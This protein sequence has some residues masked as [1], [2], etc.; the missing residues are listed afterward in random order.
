VNAIAEPLRPQVVVLA[1][2]LFH[3]EMA[4]SLQRLARTI[5]VS[6][7]AA[8]RMATGEM[9]P[10]PEGAFALNGAT[11]VTQGRTRVAAA[12]A[13]LDDL[14]ADVLV[15]GNDMAPIERGLIHAAR[16]RDIRVVLLQ[17]GLFPAW[18][19]ERRRQLGRTVVRLGHPE[20]APTVYGIGE[21]THAGLLGVGW[22]E[23]FLRGRE[24]DAGRARP[25]GNLVFAD[26]IQRVRSR[27]VSGWRR[28]IGIPD[29]PTAIFFTTDL[30][31]GL[32]ATNR[33][34]HLRQARVIRDAVAAGSGTGWTVRIRLHPSERPDDYAGL[35]PLGVILDP[36]IPL[37]AAI[38]AADVGLVSGSAV[39][40]MLA[41]AGRAVGWPVSGGASADERAAARWLGIPLLQDPATLMA[42]LPRP[43]PRR[44]ADLLADDLDDPLG[45]R[46]LRLVEDAAR[47]Q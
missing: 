25:V 24:A 9:H 5:D 15:V 32:G 29:A 19:H 38:G 7:A 12:T 2:S 35:A 16:A 18:R 34:R 4:A 28:E 42:E 37:A 30:L 22:V 3:V 43:D 44:I 6:V 36:D 10:V 17:D 21:W 31:R 33:A 41:A 14:R 13:I 20:L 39:S 40:L 23:P 47:V 45:S 1:T 8:S 27:D 46:S 11:R 26:T